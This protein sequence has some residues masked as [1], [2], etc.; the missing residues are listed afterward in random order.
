MEEACRAPPLLQPERR[1][2][3]HSGLSTSPPERHAGY[4]SCPFHVVVDPA[5]GAT[6]HAHRDASRTS[7]LEPDVLPVCDRC[8][9]RRSPRRRRRALSQGDAQREV[10]PRLL[11]GVVAS[12]VAVHPSRLRSHGLGSGV[13]VV[14]TVPLAGAG[15]RRSSSAR[16]L[17]PRPRHLRH[18]RRPACPLDPA[19]RSPLGGAASVLA[20]GRYL[21]RKAAL[22]LS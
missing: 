7:N 19:F 12:P 17:R 1:L 18:S 4:A 8:G 6:R 21:A 22:R 15:P 5:G 16:G 10:V 20:P 3:P 11:G 2:P 13:A 14:P 9:G